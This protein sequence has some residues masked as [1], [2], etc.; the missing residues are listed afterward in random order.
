MKAQTVIA[1]ID[2]L[3]A[4]AVRRIEGDLPSRPLEAYLQ[5]LLDVRQAVTY[6]AIATLERTAVKRPGA[7]KIEGSDHEWD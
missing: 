7:G 5:A 2:L 4:R 6:L 3:A 1:E